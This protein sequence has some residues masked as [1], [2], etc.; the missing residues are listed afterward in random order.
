M[1][2]YEFV[3]FELTNRSKDVE[4]SLNCWGNKGYSLKNFYVDDPHVQIIMEKEVTN[5]G[6]DARTPQH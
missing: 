5:L 4:D 6:G 1:T 2:K 3:V